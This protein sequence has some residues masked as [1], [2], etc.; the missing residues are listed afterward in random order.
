MDEVTTRAADRAAYPSGGE[1]DAGTAGVAADVLVVQAT[2]L[3][4]K[5]VAVQ[6]V[7]CRKDNEAEVDAFLRQRT[8]PLQR[9]R[10]N[11]HGGWQGIH[12]SKGLVAQVWIDSWLVE[13]P[14]RRSGYLIVRD[15]VVRELYE[16][17]R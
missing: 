9:Y 4:R 14:E 10:A 6:A 11:Q 13:E 1:S 2:T 12:D 17:L 16:V 5:P 3:T 15:D 7:Q 8:Y